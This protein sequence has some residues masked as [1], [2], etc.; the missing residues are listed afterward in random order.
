MRLR[1]H[2]DAVHERVA[3]R[4]AEPRLVAARHQ[5]LVNL[6]RKFGDQT[7]LGIGIGVGFARRM[8]DDELDHHRDRH[9]QAPNPSP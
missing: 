1:Q 8:V 7:G 4:R 6:R 9:R 5:R 3:R 2:G